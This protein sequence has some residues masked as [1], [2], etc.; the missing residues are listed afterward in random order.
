MECS[1]EKKPWRMTTAPSLIT[2]PIIKAKKKK[3]EK[4]PIC[5]NEKKKTLNKPDV[6]KRKKLQ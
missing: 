3:T 1:R 4:K 5:T 2:T 6:T